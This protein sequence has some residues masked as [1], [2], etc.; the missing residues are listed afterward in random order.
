MSK[1]NYTELKRVNKFVLIIITIIDMFLFFGY[2]EDYVKD[3]ITFGF[4][5]LIESIVLVS[6]AACYIVYFKKKDSVYF[7]NISMIGYLIVYSFA[8]L[9]AK[10]DLVFIIVFPLTIIYILYYDYKLVLRIAILFGLVNVID[11]IYVIA[12]LGHTH[13]G[14]AINTTSLLLQGACVIVY[15][16][17]LCG[18]TLISNDNNATKIANLKAEKDKSAELLNEVLKVAVSVKE[19][20]TEAETHIT[21]LS[22]Y[23][24]STAKE[25]KEIAEG[26]NNN[27]ASIEKQ[28]IMTGNIQ[29]II[30]ETK[31]MSDDMLKLAEESKEAVRNGQ[32]AVENLQ[33]QGN[34]SREANEQIVSVVAGLISNAKEVEEITEQIFSIS[35]QTNLLALNASI[36][37]ARA[38]ESGRG[39]AVVAEEIRTLADESRVLTEKIQN[40]VSELKTNAD[41]AKDTVDTVMV[42]SNT[43]HELISNADARFGEIG[44]QMNGLYTNVQN[45]YQKIE[46][47]LK[48][49]HEIVDSINHISAVS[50]EVTACTEEAAGLGED[51]TQKAEQARELM[52]KL[53]ETVQ[54]IDKYVS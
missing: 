25:L 42:A 51:T 37:S 7:K 53:L 1:K 10:N 45:I 3:N 30:L 23:V 5:L 13:S 16:I 20:S 9:G 14:N 43:E 27:T 50:E 38:G 24:A 26:N 6:M 33:L 19:N 54:S 34:K 2:F 41:I 22:E 4:M 21:Q 17:V 8:V 35:N 32:S 11:I 28:S 52:G 39:F 29:D 36:E 47:I 31:Q 40:I 49:N 46:D 18:T 48:A 44:N 15:M 12:V